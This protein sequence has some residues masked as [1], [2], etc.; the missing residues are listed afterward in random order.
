MGCLAYYIP[1]PIPCRHALV[2]N[3]VAFEDLG[4]LEAPLRERGFA[5]QTVDVSTAHF[6]LP[7][8]QSCDLLV[9][10]GGPIGGYDRLE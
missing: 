6:P 3:H 10:M 2:L 9:V 7:Q 5:I 8:A 4:S 1:M